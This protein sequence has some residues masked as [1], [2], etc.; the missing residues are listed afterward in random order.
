[1]AAS[2][3]QQSLRRKLV[4]IV[5]ILVL[6][7]ITLAWKQ[8]LDAQASKLEIRETD[9]GEVELTGAALRLSL[10]GLRGLAVCTLWQSAIDKQKKNEWNELELL[11][12]SLT[13]LQPHFVTPWL[14]QSWNLAYNVAVES[15]RIRDKYFYITRGIE[16]LAEGERQN[17]RDPDMR[18]FIGFY[19]QHKVGQGDEDR[20]MRCLFQMSCIP[21]QE[22]D[23][24]QFRIQGGT[25][26][27]MVKFEEFCRRHPML[28][29][30]LR[31][32]LKKERPEDIVD[33]LADNRRIPSR[34][35]DAAGNPGLQAVLKSPEKQFPVMPPEA[36]TSLPLGNP[37]DRDF[38]NFVCARDWYA[39]SVEPLPPPKRDLNPEVQMSFD[40]TK[41]RIPRNM[42]ATIFRGYPNR[43]QSY[44][45]EYLQK[46][47]WFDAEG[48]QINGWFPND[49]FSDGR[50]AVVGTELA[51]SLRA[52]EL[53]HNMWKDHGLASGLL[54]SEEEI[55]SIMDR[56]KKFIEKHGFQLGIPPRAPAMDE[57]DEIKRGFRELAKLHWSHM[58]QNQTNFNHFYYGSLVE[59]QPRTVTARKA[60]FAADRFRKSAKTSEAIEQYNKAFPIWQRILIEHPLYRNDTE[61]QEESYEHVVNFGKQVNQLYGELHRQLMQ[62]GN[63]LGKAA[64]L[65][66]PINL[67]HV[68]YLAFKQFPEI[69]TPLDVEIPDFESVRLNKEPSRL[70]F[71]AHKR[72]ENLIGLHGIV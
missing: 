8:N 37:E 72:V 33:F 30:R 3:Q 23:P 62:V 68:F 35:E 52:W 20:T 46:E 53:A 34:Y 22:R 69:K 50:R 61:I 19:T 16:L 70:D 40:K 67:T 48:W 41:Y 1:M 15:D 24:S 14:F 64:I 66:M 39:Y 5:V 7:S 32:G 47:G 43:G 21:P 26:I 13:K 54:M 36:V 27:D 11:I 31:E 18:Y 59:S 42:S 49:Q 45:A 56:A 9:R 28:I 2:F 71:I 17:K 60:F 58:F 4:Y 12:N 51:W 10:T 38:D 44:V 55:K 57:P 29:R 65:A 25:G 6:F 63:D